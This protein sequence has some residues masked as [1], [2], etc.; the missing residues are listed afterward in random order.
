MTNHKKE[1]TNPRKNKEEQA[2]GILARRRKL[3][4]QVKGK[5]NT[6]K[7]DHNNKKKQK[8]EE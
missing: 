7:Q 6:Y 2:R 4:I 8:P 1:K 3:K 5:R